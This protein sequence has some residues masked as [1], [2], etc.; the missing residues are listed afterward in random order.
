MVMHLVVYDYYEYNQR[1]CLVFFAF[2]SPL[3]M[4]TFLKHKG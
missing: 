2:S 1:V 4:S 3:S